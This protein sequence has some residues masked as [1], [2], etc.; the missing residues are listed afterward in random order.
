MNNFVDRWQK[1]GGDLEEELYPVCEEEFVID[2]EPYDGDD[3]WNVQFL[4][5]ITH[6]SCQF[7]SGR[8]N[9]LKLDRGHVVDDTIHRGYIHQIR[10]TKG[11]MY[12]E[13]QY[14]LGSAHV[15]DEKEEDVQIPEKATNLIPIEIVRNITDA[16]EKGVHH[17]C[18]VVMPMFPEG[19]PTSAA[20]QEILYWQSQTMEM[21]YRRIS[22]AI[23]AAE[24][25]T[26]PTDY[27]SFYCLGKRGDE[28]PEDL[29]EP[30]EDN[31]VHFREKKRF[32]IYVH[33]KMMICDDEYIIV[34]SANINQ[35]SMGGRRDTEMAVGCYQP[36]F[37]YEEGPPQ[38]DVGAFR[39]SLWGEHLGSLPEECNNPQTIECMRKVNEMA[40][41]NWLAYI[42]EEDEVPAGHLLTYPILVSQEGQVSNLEDEAYH[43]FPDTTASVL[44]ALSG[45]F[46]EK[47]TT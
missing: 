33:S 28:V 29:A 19:D 1:Q 47:L 45:I 7:S 17:S 18:Y 23:E 14:F 42:S 26:H 6:D 38:G 21:M 13:N 32:M 34:G 39:K 16:I 5:S 46:P 27:L 3:A 15:W 10:R 22:K 31:E 4:R 2:E 25:D 9:K 30:E 11:F 24:L 35:R 37:T 43:C 40:Q 20:V 44:G 12:I 41:E 36:N 8:R